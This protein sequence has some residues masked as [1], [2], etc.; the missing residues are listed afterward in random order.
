MFKCYHLDPLKQYVAKIKGRK[1]TPEESNELNFLSGVQALRNL[2]QQ[3]EKG[4]VQYVCDTDYKN[5]CNHNYRGQEPEVIELKTNDLKELRELK[6]EIE[7]DLKVIRPFLKNICDWQ[8]GACVA[9]RN[10][11]AKFPDVEPRSCCDVL[12]VCNQLYETGCVLPESEKPLLCELFLCES[13]IEM[14][15]EK[16]ENFNRG[17]DSVRQELEP[18]RQYL[19]VV[20]KYN[21]LQI[22]SYK[23]YY[24]AIKRPNYVCGK[25][26]F[27]PTPLSETGEF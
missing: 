3:H 18:L 14:L 10:M 26:C 4:L 1:L 23:E 22:P 13:A 19:D 6:A 21:K 12:Y 5:R 2:G 7:N 9:M 8:K 25:Q 11:S 24:G 16:V 15:L 27:M 20:V 17:D